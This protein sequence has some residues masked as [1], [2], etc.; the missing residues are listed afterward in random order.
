MDTGF[1]KS[2]NTA[3]EP[4]HNNR[5]IATGVRVSEETVIRDTSRASTRRRRS[6]EDGP[7]AGVRRLA[8]AVAESDP[9]RFG[10]DAPTKTVHT[11]GPNLCQRIEDVAREREER[12]E[13]Q[14]IK[15]LS[16]YSDIVRRQVEGAPCEDDA[17]VLV[18]ILQTLGWTVQSFQR[19]VR[20]LETVRDMTADLLALPSDDD[21]EGLRIAVEQAEDSLKAA[22]EAYSSVASANSVRVL[23]NAEIARLRRAH[24]YLFEPATGDEVGH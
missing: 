14:R 7:R 15:D 18:D 16:V 10:D 4:A 6:H 5:P 2:T 23:H 21:A 13:A 8:I 22:R 12:R 3:V 1:L 20:V 17:I 24:S 19:D 11:G 9:I